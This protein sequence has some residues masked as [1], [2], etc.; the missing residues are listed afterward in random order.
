MMLSFQVR[1]RRWRLPA[2]NLPEVRLRKVNAEMVGLRVG[3]P[4]L[5]QTRLGREE[6]LKDVAAVLLG[7]RRKIGTGVLASKHR[8]QTMVDVSLGWLRDVIEGVR[9]DEITAGVT[10]DAMVQVEISQGTAVAVTSCV[11]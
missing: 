10:E 8:K 6:N 9:V 1:L 7:E 11:R 3:L 2:G 5:W 4:F